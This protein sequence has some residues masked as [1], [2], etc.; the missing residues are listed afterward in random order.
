MSAPQRRPGELS[1]EGRRRI[2]LTGAAGLA[3]LLA[4]GLAGLP[5]F[6]GFTPRYGQ[7]VNQ[8]GVEDAG[9]TAVVAAVNFDYRAFDTLGE[10]F[11]LFAAVL[12]LALLLRSRRDERRIAADDDAWGRQVPPSSSAVRLTTVLIAG[13]TVLLAVYITAHGHLTPG[14][15]FQGGVIAATALLLVYLGGEYIAMSRVRPV[16]LVEVA[17]ASGAGA[18]VLIGI[19]GLIFSGAFLENFLPKGEPGELVSAGTIPLLSVAVGFE[20]AGGFVLLLSEFIE[21]LLIIRRPG[22]RT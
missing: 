8:I 5:S 1:F 20:V 19:G 3:A 6:D 9:T 17:K 11:I 15:G 7:V 14:G 4:W 13:P 16:A 10:E 2:F 22:E 18:F 21:Q 12:G